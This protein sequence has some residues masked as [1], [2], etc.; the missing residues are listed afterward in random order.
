MLIPATLGEFPMFVDQFM[1]Q[2]LISLISHLSRFSQSGMDVFG[3]LMGVS[4]SAS[5]LP[6]VSVS[7]EAITGARAACYPAILAMSRTV[8]A[9]EEEKNTPESQN[10]SGDDKSEVALPKYVI[11]SSSDNGMKPSNVVGELKFQ[12]VKFTYP[13]RLET[14]VFKEFSLTVKAGTTVALV[15]PRYVVDLLE[16]C[17]SY[18]QRIFAL[19]LHRPRLHCSVLQR[20]W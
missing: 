15:G 12:D 10:I 5:V 11:D 18:R 8:E 20:E 17:G 9:D 14:D 2:L 16:I 13:T 7:I 19:I 4:F 1:R 3:A 6:Q